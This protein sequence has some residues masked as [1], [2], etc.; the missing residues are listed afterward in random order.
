MIGEI[1]GY[2]TA[3]FFTSDEEVKNWADQSDIYSKW[4]K[5][6]IKYVDLNHDGKINWGDDTK[7]NSGDKKVIGNSTPRF[8]FGLN[9]TI[10]Y[11]DFDFGML[12]QGVAKRD[13]ALGSTLFWGFQS[14]K[15]FSNAFEHTLDYWKEDNQNAYYP[16]PYMSG[17]NTKNQ[18]IQ[19]KYLQNA[20]YV[21][22]KNLQIGYNVPTTFTNKIKLERLRI[23][24]SGEN[25]LTFSP[26]ISGIDPEAT[27][28]VYGDG[29]NYPLSRVISVG[30]NVVF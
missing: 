25:L 28:G 29:K 14:N 1:W 27:G 20:A 8:L 22:L 10:R 11:K 21:R 30:L 18:Q 17:E 16:R 12:W 19:T 15:V 26:L 24:L 6:D 3:G 13:V 2:E 4:G 5:G 9:T 7:K 23:Y